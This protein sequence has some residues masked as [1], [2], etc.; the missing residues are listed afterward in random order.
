MINRRILS[1][2]KNGSSAPRSRVPVRTVDLRVSPCKQAL[3]TPGA[4]KLFRA[5]SKNV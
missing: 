4:T 3:R 5:Y 2:D 1:F